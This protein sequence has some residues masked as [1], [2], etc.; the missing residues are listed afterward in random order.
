MSKLCR[1]SSAESWASAVQPSRSSL[2]LQSVGTDMRFDAWPHQMFFCSRFRIGAG[3][4]S[5]V[6]TDDTNRSVGEG[7]TGSS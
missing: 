6:H 3:P 4:S 2:W 7:G 5:S 1:A